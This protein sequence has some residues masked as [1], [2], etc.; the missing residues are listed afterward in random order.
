M[1]TQTL[2]AALLLS[3]LPLTAWSDAPATAPTAVPATAAPAATAPLILRY[4]FSPGQ[5]LRYKLTVDSTGTLRMATG[6]TM[7][8]KQHMEMTMRQSV[9]D[10]RASDGAATL[11]LG[12]EAVSGT[13]N[14]QAL[15]PQ[16][17]QAMQKDLGTM[18]LSPTGKV[19]SFQA[20]AP[21]GG[22]A[23]PGMDM[24]SMAQ[25]RT[26]FP[27]GPVKVGDTWKSA[28]TS[29]AVGMTM[30]TVSRLKS[31]DTSGGGSVAAIGQGI[32]GTFDMTPPV[33][34]AA[35]GDPAAPT[36]TITGTMT[37]SDTLKFDAA[38]GAVDGETSAMQMLLTIA[39]HPPAAAG[40]PPPPTLT[41]LRMHIVT[42]MQRL[43]DAP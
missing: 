4:K 10:V 33:P 23:M 11:S 29:E 2:S 19:L 1:K 18:V 9:T 42:S 8:L 35:P 40:T 30:H 5:T 37:G 3:A 34:K 16:A 17:T 12:L 38:A 21:Q 13:M 32:S 14:G 7:P 43:P 6:T 25:G 15:P 39:N 24:K 22:L 27:D 20:Q 36:T 31:L 28:I 26:V 41:K